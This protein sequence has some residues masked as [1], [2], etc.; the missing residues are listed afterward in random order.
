MG[1]CLIDSIYMEE[2]EIW[3]AFRRILLVK[4][5]HIH[6][7]N[8]IGSAAIQKSRH[9]FPNEKQAPVFIR[10]LF[11]MKN[12]R[13]KIAAKAEILAAFQRIPR[14]LE[15]LLR[16]NPIPQWYSESRTDCASIAN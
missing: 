3:F 7:R 2:H 4:G 10:K 5:L 1:A 8:D 12:D 6:M 13:G 9:H 16:S 14:A 11:K 15:A